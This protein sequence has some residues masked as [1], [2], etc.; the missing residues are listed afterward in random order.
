M[1]TF[2]N[3]L[4]WGFI[5]FVT[6]FSGDVK[7]DDILSCFCQEDGERGEGFD[8]IELILDYPVNGLYIGL[9]SMVQSSP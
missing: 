4:P 5:S 9:I 3:Y 6:V 1:V 2:M 7:P 8:L